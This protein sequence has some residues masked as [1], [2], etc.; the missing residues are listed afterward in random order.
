MVN[1]FVVDS[2]LARNASLL[3]TKRLGKQRIEAKEIIDI[4][5]S[6]DRGVIPKKKGWM[7]HPAT[8][9]W[10]GYTNAL[11]VYYNYILTE[12]KKRSDH[13][14]MQ[15]Y[16]IDVSL[17]YVNPY[18]GNGNFKFP[19]T[20]YSFPP[21]FAFP[22]F[23]LAQ[24]ASL[25]RKSP[26]IYNDIFNCEEIQPYLQYGYLWPSNHG[27][28]IYTNWDMSYLSPIPTCGTPSHFTITREECILFIQK[29]YC[30]PKTGRKISP[31]AKIY[32]DY[33]EACKYYQL[34]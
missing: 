31:G 16:D 18:I 14:T 34:I 6:L 13:N 17:Y 33:I 24:R 28:Y 30:N 7:N 26:E 9:M 21:W 22:P 2:D 4:L 29:P 5:E 11:K 15:Y 20:E 8:K 32:N 23:I 19:F 10:Y 25:I 27:N 1:T 3:D 12:F